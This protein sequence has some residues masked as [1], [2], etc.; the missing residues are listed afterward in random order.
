MAL[1]VLD[2]LF[3][4]RIN[5]GFILITTLDNVVKFKNKSMVSKKKIDTI[6]YRLL[7][8]AAVIDVIVIVSF[9]YLEMR[10]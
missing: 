2:F 5:L 3:G 10:G 7:V 6:F 1:F 8:A 9:Y 4:H